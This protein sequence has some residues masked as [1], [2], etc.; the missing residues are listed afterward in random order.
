MLFCW[1]KSIK[2]KDR[3]QRLVRLLLGRLLDKATASHYRNDDDVCCLGLQ[4]EKEDVGGRKRTIAIAF[5]R[6][7]CS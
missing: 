6:A 7:V 4:K 3:W 1:K 2:A 5:V